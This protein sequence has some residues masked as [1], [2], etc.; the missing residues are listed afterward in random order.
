MLMPCVKHLNPRQG[1]TTCVVYAHLPY[2]RTNPRVKHLNPRQGI[3]TLPWKRL[4][5]QRFQMCVKHLNPRQGITTYSYH[6]R[7]A[8]GHYHYKV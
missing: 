1:I 4:V 6:S 5:Q 7:S 8:P 2:T 3:T